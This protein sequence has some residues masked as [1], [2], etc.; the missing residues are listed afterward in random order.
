MATKTQRLQGHNDVLSLLNMA[1]DA[2]N[3]AKEATSVAP[4]K[5]AFTSTGVLLAM[6]KVG[7]LPVQ[8]G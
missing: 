5:T 4:A 6:I 8:V 2:L 1:I 7:F 3:L